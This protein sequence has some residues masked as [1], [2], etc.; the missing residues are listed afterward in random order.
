MM[1]S[2]DLP[3]R[4]RKVCQLLGADGRI[5]FPSD[6]PHDA[7]EACFDAALLSTDVDAIRSAAGDVVVVDGYRKIR[8][9]DNPERFI[10]L[11]RLA[12]QAQSQFNVIDREIVRLQARRAELARL[13]GSR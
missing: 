8:L 5:L 7:A 3:V 9:A 2:K 4:I 11:R 12:A 6:T 10:N 13:I 1:S